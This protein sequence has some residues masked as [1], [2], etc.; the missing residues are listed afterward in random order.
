MIQKK[1]KTAK[2][3]SS[4]KG[5]KMDYQLSPS[6]LNLLEDCPRC[7]WLATVKKIRRPSG[8]M[9]GIVIKMDSI[10]KHYFNKYRE[11]GQLPPIIIGKIQGKLPEDMPKTLKHDEGDGII[12]MGRPDDYFELKDGNIVAFD[13]KTKSKAPEGTHPA[14]QLQLDVYS[15][16]L[17]AK[18]YKTTNKAYLA[19]YYPD[20]CDL[21]NGMCMNCAIIEV[22]T[23][24]NRAKKLVEKAREILEG[25]IPKHGENC[26]FCK[27]VDEN[28]KI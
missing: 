22:K 28:I 11:Q 4:F 2:D 16:L 10:I 6:K 13:H 19:Y 27:W 20:D 14:Y 7:F 9:A 8:P 25:D 26:E 24:P 1:L 21:H 12:L 17:K 15:Y 5:G 18:G 23:N 3:L